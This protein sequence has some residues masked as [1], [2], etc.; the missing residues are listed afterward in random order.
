MEFI[1]W[2]SFGF[3]VYTSHV[4]GGALTLFD[5]Y[6]IT[7]QKKKKKKKDVMRVFQML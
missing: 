1:L 4:L 2:A 6:N 5:I 7:Y 3:P